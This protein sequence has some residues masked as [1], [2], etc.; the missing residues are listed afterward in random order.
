MDTEPDPN[1]PAKKG[2]DINSNNTIDSAHGEQ[3]SD[4]VA[5]GT[6][7]MDDDGDDT[8]GEEKRQTFRQRR[9]TY[10]LETL[11]SSELQDLNVS[12]KEDTIKKWRHI[13]QWRQGPHSQI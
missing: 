3:N 2:N 10:T 1:V 13:L 8:Q 4:D 7:E 6:I 12:E 9:L 11:N 5:T